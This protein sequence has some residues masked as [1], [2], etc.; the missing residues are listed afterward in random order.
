[1]RAGELRLRALRAVGVGA[2]RDARGAAAR[3]HAAR[4]DRE[5][6]AER[7]REGGGGVSAAMVDAIG[8]RRRMVKPLRKWLN[9]YGAALAALFCGAAVL[10]AAAD[11]RAGDGEIAASK[12]ATFKRGNDE[13]FHGRYAEAV[14]AYE[15]V[16]ALG[17]RSEDL[18]YNLGNAYAKAGQ[19]GPAI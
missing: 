14:A 9:H 6:Q 15:Q 13:Y 5:G 18:F 8:A 17:V 10:G 11:A 1:A 19:L 12:D 2:G 7:E 3:A 16:A 4:L